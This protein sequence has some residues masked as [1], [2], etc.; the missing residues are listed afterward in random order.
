MNAN[1]TTET[2]KWKEKE[3]TM[4]DLETKKMKVKKQ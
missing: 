1:G 3:K 2:E 4:R